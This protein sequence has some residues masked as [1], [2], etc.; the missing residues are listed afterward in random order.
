MTWPIFGH[1]WAADL[2]ANHIAHDSV[3][4][5]YLFCGP[6]GVGRR[7]LALRFAQAL[8]CLQPPAP[9]QACGVCRMCEQTWRQQQPDLH[10]IQIAE[11]AQ[12]IKIEQ[13]R[14]LQRLLA[15]SPYQARYR[16]ALLLSF[17]KA[18]TGAQ[19]A[20]LKTLEEAPEKV[21]LL[22]TAD[23]PDNLLP[24]I[25]SRCEILRLRPMKVERLADSLISNKHVPAQEA[26]VLAHIAAG[27][28]GLALN[29]IDDHE[30]AKDRTHWLEHLHAALSGGIIERFNLAER[31]TKD[32]NRLRTG[33]RTW[34]TYWRDLMLVTARADAPLT[35]LD[36]AEPLEAVA[37]QIDFDTARRAASALEAALEDIDL[38]VNPRLLL[39]VTL[40]DW[41]RTTPVD[42]PAI[43]QAE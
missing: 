25:T 8:N 19:N 14:E 5:A 16:I 10:I 17:E 31:L 4:H 9:G 11:D 41:P 43:L 26:T 40:L 37:A 29:L 28:P 27:R 1:E 15:L 35:N 32:K 3:R 20:L 39:E 34:L 21:V 30:T 22:L 7:T 23:S 36:F 33:M 6:P 24:T 38:N 2:L 13:V 42:L 12:T 18:T